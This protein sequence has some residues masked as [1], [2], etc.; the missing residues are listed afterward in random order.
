M[1]GIAVNKII[2]VAIFTW[3]KEPQPFKQ[4]NPQIDENIDLRLNGDLTAYAN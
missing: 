1:A 3:R 4:E 2:L